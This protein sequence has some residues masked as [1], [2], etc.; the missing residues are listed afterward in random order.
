MYVANILNMKFVLFFVLTTSFIYSQD[1]A[2]IKFTELKL[3]K[4]KSLHFKIN[5]KII[6][7]S[8]TIYSVPVNTK[9]ILDTIVYSYNSDFKTKQIS[10]AKF[11]KNRTYVIRINPCSGYE[12]FTEKNRKK[13]R[14]KILKSEI[15]DSNTLCFSSDLVEIPLIEENFNRW[16][17]YYLSAMCR[18]SYQTF[19]LKQGEKVLDSRNFHFLHREKLKIE[20]VNSKICFKL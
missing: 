20:L 7:A 9:R 1:K 5:G 13:G 2:T 8:D 15:D 12:L 10:F 11:K 19:E 3:L 17:D 16:F 14:I 4:N 18:Y 6:K